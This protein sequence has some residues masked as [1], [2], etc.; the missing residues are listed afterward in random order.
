[1]ITKEVTVTQ[2]VHVTVDPAKFTPAFM[3]DFC[4]H[5]YPFDTVDQH[6]AH[7]GQLHVRG[8]ADHHSFIEGYGNADDMGIRFF[9]ANGS[10]EIEVAA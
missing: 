10:T 3:A 2:R 7:L 1:M 5:F 8:L 6:L 9:V 4:E